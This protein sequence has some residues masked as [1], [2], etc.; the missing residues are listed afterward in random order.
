MRTLRLLR[1]RS[2]LDWHCRG[3]RECFGD[4]MM[5]EAANPRPA[6]QTWEP[7]HR[8]VRVRAGFKQQSS[9]MEGRT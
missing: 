3:G 7:R 9:S 8:S 5:L 1:M 6:K 4:P 2:L